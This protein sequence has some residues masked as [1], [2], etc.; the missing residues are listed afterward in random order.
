M[1]IDT[2][3]LSDKTYQAIMAEAGKF[4][5][6]LT[7]RF[8]LLSYRCTDEKDFIDKSVI[9]IHE[10]LRFDD[11]EMDDMFFGEP[12]TRKS[13]YRILNKILKNIGAL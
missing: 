9:L 13:F 8:G 4:D 2:D 6:N 1:A 5:E 11:A 10:M 12:P 7:L 3:D